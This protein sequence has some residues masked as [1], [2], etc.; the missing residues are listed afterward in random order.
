ME[1]KSKIV[2]HADDLGL[3]KVLNRGIK[4]AYK[5][6]VLQSMCIRTNG[7][8]SRDAMDKV[9]PDCKELSVGLRL[10]LVEEK[11]HL[12]NPRSFNK[13]CDKN[14]KNLR[15]MDLGFCSNY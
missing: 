13:I 8:F 2:F 12:S 11:S 10:N 1:Y 9:I 3:T 14:G 15:E 5:N 7:P 6:G 4:L